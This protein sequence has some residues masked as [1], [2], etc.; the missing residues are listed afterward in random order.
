MST[1]ED[2]LLRDISTVS[3]GVLVTDSDLRDAWEGI[4]DRIQN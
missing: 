4:D 3:R 2:R 1:I